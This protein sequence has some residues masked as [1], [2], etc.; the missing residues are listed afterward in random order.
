MRGNVRSVGFSP[1]GLLVL[2]ILAT[3]AWLSNPWIAGA[4]VVLAAGHIPASVL[5]A[6]TLA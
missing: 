2:V 6:R 5:I 1:L 4:A 3:A